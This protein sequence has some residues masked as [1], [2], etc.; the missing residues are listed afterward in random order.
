MYGTSPSQRGRKIIIKKSEVR[1]IAD[2][3]QRAGCWW[4]QSYTYDLISSI[5]SN[6]HI[7]TMIVSFL[8]YILAQCIYRLE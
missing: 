4:L 1:I 7:K 2:A 3:Y 6:K 5:G 8:M